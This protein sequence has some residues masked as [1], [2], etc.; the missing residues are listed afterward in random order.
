MGCGWGYF[1]VDK[2]EKYSES[3][4]LEKGIVTKHDVIVIP[5]SFR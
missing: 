5:R 1:S 3:A 2:L 4:I